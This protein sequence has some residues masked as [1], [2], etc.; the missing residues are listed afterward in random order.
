MDI[1]SGRSC[2]SPYHP[3]ALIFKVFDCCSSLMCIRWSMKWL[4]SSSYDLVGSCL[5]WLI[6]WTPP[7]NPLGLVNWTGKCFGE[8][9]LGHLYCFFSISNYI[10]I[11][12]YPCIPRTYY[13][14]CNTPST[15]I[16]VLGLCYHIN[17]QYWKIWS[18][19]HDAYKLPH[20]A[21]W[22]Q[23]KQSKYKIS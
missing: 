23:Y 16:S 22:W 2:T 11:K 12:H 17:H 4:L 9:S 8:E 10:L 1:P 20:H 7:Y 6:Y 18:L 21:D 5:L 13:S 19:A 15:H 14:L 3:I